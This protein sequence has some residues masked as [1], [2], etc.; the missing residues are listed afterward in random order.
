MCFG[1]CFTFTKSPAN[2]GSRIEPKTVYT[3]IARGQNEDGS[4]H[5]RFQVS[6]PDRLPNQGPYGMATEGTTLA[7]EMGTA[8]TFHQ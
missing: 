1:G 3:V 5:K 8:L 4:W 2:R 7:V 6:T